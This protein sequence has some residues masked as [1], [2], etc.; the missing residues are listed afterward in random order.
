MFFPHQTQMMSHRVTIE[1]LDML[2]RHVVSRGFSVKDAPQ[3]SSLRSAHSNGTSL[4]VG[5]MGDEGDAKGLY[6]S[7]LFIA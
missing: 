5:E 4:P 7:I 1:S 3:P 6:A 2:S